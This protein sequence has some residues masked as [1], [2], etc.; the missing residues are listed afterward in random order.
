MVEPSESPDD[1]PS[2]GRLT[3]EEDAVLRRL[4]WFEEFGVE[5][6]PRVDSLKSSIRERDKR[7]EIREPPDV[8][9]QEPIY[10]D[11]EDPYVPVVRDS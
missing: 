5:L 1:Q 8:V 4:H 10:D 2:D 6:T 3:P 7:I 11:P 9:I